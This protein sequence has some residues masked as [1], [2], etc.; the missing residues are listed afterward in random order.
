[1][2]KKNSNYLSNKESKQI[3]RYNV[4]QMRYY[5]KE[6]KRKKH[7]ARFSYDPK[8]CHSYINSTGGNA[9]N[10]HEPWDIVGEIVVHKIGEGA[11]NIK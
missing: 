11:D 9:E 4:E 3:A 8:A 10:Y 7:C 2:A 5:E 6:K 1:M